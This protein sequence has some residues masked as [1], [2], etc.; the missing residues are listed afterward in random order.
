[1]IKKNRTGANNWYIYHAK[2]TVPQSRYLLFNTASEAVT[3]NEWGASGPSSTLA[4]ANS[5]PAGDYI[6]MC[7]HSV[8]GYSKAGVYTGNGSADGTNVV[9]GFKPRYVMIK[10]IDA[11]ADW[12]ILDSGRSGYNLNNL[13]LYANLANAE[14]VAGATVVDFT[15]NGFK[16]RGTH[17]SGNASGGTYI[18][19]AISEAPF[20][21]ALGR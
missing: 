20:K 16:L 11:A 7:F 17:A 5:D 2:T 1:M 21:Y 18:F 6:L 13:D 19:Y 15:A 12:Q 9:C 3:T 14:E 8:V 4:Y 10:R